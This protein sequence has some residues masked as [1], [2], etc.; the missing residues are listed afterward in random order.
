MSSLGKYPDRDIK[1]IAR[2]M[3]SYTSFSWGQ[4]RF[5]DSY[6]FLAASLESLTENLAAEVLYTLNSFENI[7]KTRISHVFCYK[8]ENILT[9]T[10]PIVKFSKRPAY[11]QLRSFTAH[12]QNRRFPRKDTNMLRMYGSNL[13]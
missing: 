10:S 13:R 12:C 1:V 9:N 11:R 2:T 6:Q 8:K 4:I 7:F 5:L 3:E